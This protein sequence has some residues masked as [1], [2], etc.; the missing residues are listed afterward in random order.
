MPLTVGGGVRT[1]EDARALLLAGADKISIN[2]AAVERPG[3]V[4]RAAE[5]FG[6][7]CI[8]VAIDAKRVA[9]PASRP[10]GDVHP[11]RPQATGLDAVA[12]AREAWRSG[13]AKSCSPPWTA[14]A[15]S[16]GY[17]LELTR[18]DGRCGVACR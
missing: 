11:R 3:L 7:Q 13:R 9:Q 16:A 1:V 6:S 2:T 8:V 14:T 17:D 5:K 15:P 12:Y 10:L 4:H 18:A